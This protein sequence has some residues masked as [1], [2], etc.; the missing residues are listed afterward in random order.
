MQNFVVLSNAPLKFGHVY[1]F[2]TK[3]TDRRYQY[4]LVHMFRI[5]FP[6]VLDFIHEASRRS[7][8]NFVV[9]P[10]CRITRSIAYI[11]LFFLTAR[12]SNATVLALYFI[13]QRINWDLTGVLVFCASNI[14]YFMY[15]LH[16]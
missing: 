8:V 4:H 11:C 13:V 6:W 15:L 5:V 16:I 3:K 14:L 2:P 9:I 10:L 7:I 1:Y 12:P